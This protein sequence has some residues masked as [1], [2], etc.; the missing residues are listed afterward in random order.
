MSGKRKS[1]KLARRT[2][3]IC[4]NKA[5]KKSNLHVMKIPQVPYNQENTITLFR[6]K[7]D[8]TEEIK[9]LKKQVTWH[10]SNNLQKEFYS[11]KKEMAEVELLFDDL[12]KK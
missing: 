12:I 3:M 2:E 6:A 10:Q 11:I 1:D 7:S 8:L 4:R 9:A 5:E